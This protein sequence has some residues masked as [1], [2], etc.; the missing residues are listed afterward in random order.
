LC[1]LQVTGFFCCMVTPMLQYDNIAC[2]SCSCLQQEV[3]GRGFWM[4]YSR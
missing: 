4:K 3:T 2:M 1:L